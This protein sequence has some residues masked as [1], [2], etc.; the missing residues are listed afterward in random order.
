MEMVIK[1]LYWMSWSCFFQIIKFD[2]F[3]RYPFEAP[4]IRFVTPV[5]HPNVDSMGR[6]CLDL[7]KMPPA[8]SIQNKLLLGAV[9]VTRW[10][11]HDVAV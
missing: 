4:K 10:F 7:L 9:I 8:V 2:I 11:M 1:L 5:Y 3:Y 6:I